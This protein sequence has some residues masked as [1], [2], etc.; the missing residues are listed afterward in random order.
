MLL[1]I[2]NYFILKQNKVTG[3]RHY[4]KKLVYN[5]LKELLIDKTW[6]SALFKEKIII[7]FSKKS[8]YS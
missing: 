1:M 3:I 5:S 8:F 4:S 6:K 7:F 2:I